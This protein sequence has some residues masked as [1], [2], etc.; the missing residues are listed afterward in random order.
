M[1]VKCKAQRVG[2]AAVRLSM[3]IQRAI[4]AINIDSADDGVKGFREMK[5]GRKRDSRDVEMM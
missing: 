1:R 2:Y 3:A 4:K 5:R